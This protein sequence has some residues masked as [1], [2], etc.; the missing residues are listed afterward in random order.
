[1][2]I[3][4]IEDDL[5]LGAAIVRELKAEGFAVEWE[6]T[7]SGGLFRA[8]EWDHDLVI[9]DRLLPG[10]DGTEVLRSLRKKKQVPVLMLTALNRLTDRVKGLDLGADDY[11][12][13]PFELAELLARIRALL[14][15]SSAWSDEALTHGD[16][17]F[18]FGAK[19]VFKGGK[20]VVLRAS[21]F[22]TVELLLSRKGR[23]VSKQVLEERLHEDFGKFQSNSLE[24]H[25]HRIRSKLGHDFIQTKRGLGYLVPRLGGDT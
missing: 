21:E 4:L 23:P 17:E 25:I 7:G 12:G 15:R 10:M 1:M 22:A 18:H 2:L 13:K 6:R 24:V 19:R 9:L 14:R 11:L 5:D 16:L 20:E 3:L 8:I